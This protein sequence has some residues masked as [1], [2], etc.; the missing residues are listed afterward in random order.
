MDRILP[1]KFLRGGALVAL[2]MWGMVSAR[3]QPIDTNYTGHYELVAPK[4]GRT[5]VLDVKQTKTRAQVSFSAAMADGSGA[6]PDGSGNG[7][8]E[9][10]ALSF[11]FK[12][13]FDN[14]GTCELRSGAGG[15][16][17]RM[18]VIKVV[19]PRPFHFYGNVRLKKTSDKTE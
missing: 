4:A 16:R 10:G 9:D 13:S 1:G 8:V 11:A 2:L 18:T 12:D 3:A 19:D 15:Y 7:R 5:F 14:E 17:L 6:A